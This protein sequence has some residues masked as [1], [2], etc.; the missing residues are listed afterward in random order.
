MQNKNKKTTAKQQQFADIF[1]FTRVA[2]SNTKKQ[3]GCIELQNVNKCIQ[4]TMKRIFM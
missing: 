3:Q 2:T 1:I 4:F